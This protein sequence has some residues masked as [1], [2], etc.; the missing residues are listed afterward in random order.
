MTDTID[1]NPIRFELWQYLAILDSEGHDTGSRGY[2][3]GIE[4]DAQGDRTGRGHVTG[5]GQ[6]RRGGYFVP[7][8]RLQAATAPAKKTRGDR[9]DDQ[10]K[11]Y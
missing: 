2:F 10:L 5:A 8:E 3:D 4:V 6:G 1:L 9:Q 11:F 7:L